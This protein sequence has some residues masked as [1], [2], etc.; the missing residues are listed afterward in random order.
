M[1]SSVGDDITGRCTYSLIAINAV[2]GARLAT[3]R[4]ARRLAVSI[5]T[6]RRPRLKW[7][8]FARS[9]IGAGLLEWF[10]ASTQTTEWTEHRHSC[11]DPVGRASVTGKLG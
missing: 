10:T 2:D 1:C 11:K 3:S 8:G 7:L 9:R 4:M 6:R 5:D